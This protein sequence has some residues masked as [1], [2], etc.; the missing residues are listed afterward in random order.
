MRRSSKKQNRRMKRTVRR[1]I[2]A[3]CLISA[4]TIAAIPVPE[5]IAY[6]PATDNIPN[7]SE[8]KATDDPSQTIENLAET[9]GLEASDIVPGLVGPQKTYAVS[10]RNGIVSLDW[11]FEVKYTDSGQTKTNGFIT[12]YNDSY[13]S[14]DSTLVVS[15]Y[16][17]ADYAYI[18]LDK[19]K[20]V[21][22]KESYYDGI[23]ETADITVY[24]GTKQTDRSIKKLGIEY[25]LTGDPYDYIGGPS[26][27][28]NKNPDNYRL[29]TDYINSN[30]YKFFAEHFSS[31]LS[32]YLTHIKNIK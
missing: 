22:E 11:Q 3:L 18:E 4:I 12:K 9:K 6:N 15:N 32:D 5:N 19:A 20:E 30:Q 27:E 25:T 7:Y 16:L 1:T 21:T 10:K 28:E 13:V 2:G 8:V 14:D 31:L 26:D 29:K 17:F 24:Y 23:S